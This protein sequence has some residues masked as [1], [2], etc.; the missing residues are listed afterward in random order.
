MTFAQPHQLFG[1]LPLSAILLL[2]ACS[3]GGGN[4]GGS[5]SPAP[6][7]T[8]PAVSGT[9]TP[10]TFTFEGGVATLTVSATDAGTVAT[11]SAT[12]SGTPVTLT[13]TGSTWT[14]SVAIPG[15]G[16]TTGASATLTVNLRATDL[17]GNAGVASVA[18][19]VTAADAP[20]AF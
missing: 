1:A 19:T 12:V 18:A 2:T 15:N 11:T 7:T 3:G 13:Q 14:G 17:A 9:L 6:D 4:S 20:P 5:S 16:S 8:V 10:N